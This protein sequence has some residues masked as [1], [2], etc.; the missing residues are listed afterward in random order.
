MVAWFHELFTLPYD[1]A[2]ERARSGIG[3]KHVQIRMPMYLMIVGMSVFRNSVLRSVR[4]HYA[5]PDE[6]EAVSR[7]LLLALDMELALMLGAYRD[8]ELADSQVRHRLLYAERAME[9]ARSLLRDHF[10]TALCLAELGESSREGVAPGARAALVTTLRD[11]ADLGSV[12]AQPAGDRERTGASELCGEAVDGVR[13]APGRRVHVD[14]QPPD[15]RIHVWA[16]L[17]RFALT[18]MLQA[19]ARVSDGDVQLDVRRSS[20]GEVQFLLHAQGSRWAAHAHAV[21]GSAA[22]GEPSLLDCVAA[23]HGGAI[24]AEIE[25]PNRA[26]VIL[27]IVA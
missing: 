13:H 26:C 20:G 14:V 24:H 18:E 15:L 22:D 19:A 17:L 25:T 16:R 5:A 1:S 6:Q 2:Y 21:G 11:M 23:I 4:R 27:R 10:D 9:R 8:H 7:A 12:V 3:Q